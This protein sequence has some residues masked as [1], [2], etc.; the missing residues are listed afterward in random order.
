MSSFPIGI[1]DMDRE[2]LLKLDPI[3]LFNACW[4]NQYT[5]SICNNEYFWRERFKRDFPNYSFPET[6]S[7]KSYFE[8]YLKEIVRVGDSIRL[9]MI[10][11]ALQEDKLHRPNY[12]I[13]VNDA[14]AESSWINSA[15][16]SYRQDKVDLIEFLMRDLGGGKIHLKYYTEPWLSLKRLIVNVQEDLSETSMNVRDLSEHEVEEVSELLNKFREE[17]SF[18]I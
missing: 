15:D 11:R 12:P 17:L 4:T 8:L 13:D 10:G 3:S 16:L 2:I 6:F 9:K 7:A 5:N 14:I 1:V 18:L